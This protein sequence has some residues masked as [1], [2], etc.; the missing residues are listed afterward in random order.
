MFKTHFIYF[1]DLSHWQ[2]MKYSQFQKI[3]SGVVIFSLL[4][5]ITF[6]IPLTLFGGKALAAD[7]PFY[8]LV[9]IL[10]E[11]TI[12]NEVKSKVQRYAS[13]I[14]A[15]LENTKVVIIPTP[16]SAHPFTVASLN[17]SLYFD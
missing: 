2:G 14:Q 15:Q 9:S 5:S 7:K 4:F 16:T 1:L 11:D 12:Y 13:D 17:E 8:N 6:H 10:V 3:I